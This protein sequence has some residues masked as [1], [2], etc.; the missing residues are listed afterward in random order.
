MTK[1]NTA[2]NVTLK[3]GTE[4][5]KTLLYNGKAVSASNTWEA[6]EVISVYFDGTNYQASNAQ[7]GGGK[8]EKIKYDNSQSRL[9][10]DNVQ[11]AVDIV[12]E[13]II[14][15][16]PVYDD[17]KFSFSTTSSTKS[18]YYL[19]AIPFVQ[20]GIYRLTFTLDDV[21]ENNVDLYLANSS[22]RSATG[23]ARIIIGA[24]EAGSNT[25]TI[26][27]ICND[28]TMLYPSIN[29]TVATSGSLSILVEKQ[30]YISTEMND[31]QESVKSLYITKDVEVNASDGFEIAGY[32]ISST[33]WTSDT[34]R[35]IQRISVKDCDSVTI[36]AL[37]TEGRNTSYSFITRG[38]YGTSTPVYYCKGYSYWVTVP[39]GETVTVDV[40]ELAEYIIIYKNYGG[41]V[42]FPAK[43][44]FHKR[45][46]P[47]EEISGAIDFAENAVDKRI[48]GAGYS[49]GSYTIDNASP[50]KWSDSAVGA[51]SRI[52]PLKAGRYTL[53]AD[54]GIGIY[55]IL[56]SVNH[57]HGETPDWADDFR[58]RLRLNYGQSTT[59]E[60][61]TDSYLWCR[62]DTETPNPAGNE[63]LTIIPEVSNTEFLQEQLAS[64]NKPLSTI[65][66]AASDSTSYDKARADIVCTG[67]D[68]NKNIETAISMIGGTKG[69][70]YLCRG[71]YYVTSFTEDTDGTFV[72]IRIP[73][74]D[75]S[76]KMVNIEGYHWGGASYQDVRIVV[77]QTT[78]DSLD[79]SKNYSVIRH[80]YVSTGY[81]LNYRLALRHIGFTIY[82]NQKKITVIDCSCSSQIVTEDIN[83]SV[84]TQPG[85]WGAG[86]DG[87]DPIPSLDCVFFRGVISS[88]NAWSKLKDT[89]CCGYGIGMGIQGEH[90]ISESCGAINCVYGFAFNY[91]NNKRVSASMDVHP[92]MI[93]NPIEEGCLNYP[94][95]GDN[96]Q[97]QSI[98]IQGYHNEHRPKFFN[99]GGNYATEKVPGQWY[100]HVDY[101]IQNFPDSHS[102]GTE[103]HAVAIPFWADGSGVNMESRNMVHKSITTS[104]IRMTYAPNYAQQIFDTTANKLLICTDPANKTWVDANGN[105]VQ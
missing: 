63:M 58:G 33:T 98:I 23:L 31:V 34:N 45:V 73:G 25:K 37:S 72:G 50:S 77:D 1:V 80:A 2:N 55:A 6:N 30:S 82:S 10:A 76:L 75:S 66:V 91:F 69:T 44:V 104:A 96:P 79:S 68:D 57:I 39:Y 47:T 90:L 49:V 12:G 19:R 27:Y 64:Y 43:L 88:C 70:V 28:A 24:I 41:T 59:I 101:V 20:G 29:C 97:K 100:G 40:P 8:A 21:K 74:K 13:E 14:S 103:M 87:L 67:T 42:F 4:T 60:L 48:D 78:Y 52:V 85:V 56:K 89:Y 51:K 11:E 93:I 61:S 83:G 16:A 38:I 7:G 5:A 32:N 9:V 3:I 35:K 46:N 17:D 95:F 62:H 105:V 18:A 53:R 81:N 15:Y 65:I 94:Y 84:T 36:T 92:M 99:Q 54:N 22:N 102:H 71:T 86:D 26:D